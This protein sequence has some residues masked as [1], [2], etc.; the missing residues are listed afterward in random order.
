[1]LLDCEKA[2]KSTQAQREHTTSTKKVRLERAEMAWNQTH[3]L[4]AVKQQL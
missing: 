1:M 2:I 3:N 4:Y